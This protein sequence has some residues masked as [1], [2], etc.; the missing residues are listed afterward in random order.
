MPEKNQKRS[1]TET[2]S[3]GTSGRISHDASRFYNSRLYSGLQKGKDVAYMENPIP[4]KH[5]NRIFCKSSEEMDELP[6]CSVHL[7]VTSP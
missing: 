6:D 1:S 7:M 2:S 5:Q 4:Q 3:F